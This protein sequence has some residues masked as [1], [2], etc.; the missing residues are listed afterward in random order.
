M[1]DLGEG[2]LKEKNLVIHWGWGRE[3]RER[4]H[5]VFCYRA[6]GEILER[7]GFE[8]VGLEGEVKICSYP[9]CFHGWWLSVAACWS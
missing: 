3:E 4:P 5:Q 2:M 1:D 9:T 7:E 6:W 8:N